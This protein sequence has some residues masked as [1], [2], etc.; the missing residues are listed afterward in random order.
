[1][2]GVLS[3]AF[4]SV[5][6]LS[7]LFLALNN[8]L[9]KAVQRTLKAQSLSPLLAHLDKGDNPAL[10][11][12][13]HRAI[14]RLWTSHEREMATTLVRH[15]TLAH[16]QAKISQYWMNQALTIEPVIARENFSD[17]FLSQY[18]NPKVASQCG[19]AG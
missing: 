7:L 15:L 13:Y 18:F 6:F 19:P 9:E 3:I 12:M 4:V 16:P 14:N 10:P 8:P 5:L 1:M 17:D 2:T 11:Q